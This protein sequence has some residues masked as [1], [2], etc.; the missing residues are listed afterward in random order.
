MKFEVR[1]FCSILSSCS[2]FSYDKMTVKDMSWRHL[3]VS[4]SVSKVRHKIFVRVQNVLKVIGKKKRN[5][6]FSL[7]RHFLYSHTV[8]KVIDYAKIVL[9]CNSIWR[10]FHNDDH[11]DDSDYI[12][13]CGFL[14][15]PVSVTVD[16]VVSRWWRLLGWS[17]TKCT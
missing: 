11:D 2:H 15:L 17:G 9:T 4:P 13:V 16:F 8:S 1:E 12:S 6:L 5:T 14:L 10:I 3:C 7:Y